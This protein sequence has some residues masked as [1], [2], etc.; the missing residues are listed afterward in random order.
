MVTGVLWPSG[1]TGILF[2]RKTLQIFKSDPSS[3]ASVLASAT[4]P[5]GSSSLTMGKNTVGNSGID[6]DSCGNLY[7]GSGNGLYKY[8][9]NLNVITSVSTSYHVYDVAVSTNGNVVFCGATGHNT[10]ANRDGYI[11]SQNI[12]TCAPMTLFCCNANICPAGPFCSTDP[13]VTLTSAQAAEYGAA[14][15]TDASLGIFRSFGSWPGTHTIIYTL[16]C[17]SDTI[18]IKVNLT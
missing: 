2:I 9:A 7:V 3:N 17:G 16:P 8:D 12:A 15:I 13:P 6:I 1:Q 11:Q 10:V 14:G 5:G 18:K 4:I